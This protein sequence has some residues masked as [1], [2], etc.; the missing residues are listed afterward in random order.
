MGENRARIKKCNIEISKRSDFLSSHP[1]IAD[2]KKTLQAN[3]ASAQ[4]QYLLATQH[5]KPAHQH[6]DE[7]VTTTV[8]TFNENDMIDAARYSDE[9][10]VALVN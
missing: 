4:Q 8:M 9:S 2:R 6:V 1:D 7:N 3:M 5:Q 10:F